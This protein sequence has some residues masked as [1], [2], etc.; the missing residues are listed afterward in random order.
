MD[1]AF[2]YA[3]SEEIKRIEHSLKIP[4]DKAFLFWI[5]KNILHL[6]D[7]D[8]REAISVEGANDKGMDIFWVDEEGERVI[9]AQG[10]HSQK[11][12]YRAKE[13]AVTEL[14]SCLDWLSDPVSLGK[15]GRVELAQAAEDY[16]EAMKKDYGIEL[17]YVY[18]GPRSRNVEKK[19]EIYNRNQEN[20]DNGR[21][22]RH[23]Y[24]KL[25][26][27]TYQELDGMPY[28]ITS[29]KIA[30]ASDGAL[31]FKGIFGKAL[32]AS[33]PGSE[34]ARLYRK[35]KDLLFSGNVRLFLP[36]RKGSV[37]AEIA[38]T[39]ANSNKKGNFWAFNNGITVVCDKFAWDGNKIALK[40]FSIVN[41]CQTTVSIATASESIED[42]YVLARFIQ[43]SPTIVEDII[44][45][46]N[47]QNKIRAWDMASRLKTQRILKKEFE[48]LNQPYNYQIRPGEKPSDPDKFKKPGERRQQKIGIETMGQYAA[49]FRKDPVLAHKNKA[50]IFER[51]HDIVFPPDVTVELVLFQWICGCICSEVVDSVKAEA[52]KDENRKKEVFILN[53]G[54]ALFVLS[55]MAHIMELRNG[56]VYLSS[57]EEEQITSTRMAERLKKYA[58]YVCDVYIGAVLDQEKIEKG[59]LSTLIRQ[60]DFHKNV[61]DR[62]ARDYRQ[63]DR[64]KEWLSEALP[65]LFKT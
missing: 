48:E 47:S 11:F 65:E 31:E 26:R 61:L 6:T 40:G 18:T 3:F 52:K 34:L 17:W 32:I 46:N 42:V 23:F 43:A 30:V 24:N 10:K 7:S 58:E 19:I 4:R 57:I 56:K 28:S 22:F 16:C 45:F 53:K 8:A 13:N 49:S 14:R 33:I 54:G 15:E 36:A 20:I 51:E 60:K 62:V 12:G 5:A 50:F 44:R 25:I 21:R 64:A 29:D 41:G 1:E 59:E 37:N 38:S 9:I 27:A 39:L 63:R 2:V 55:A 35:Y